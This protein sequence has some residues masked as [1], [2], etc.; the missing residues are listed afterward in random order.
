MGALVT[1]TFIDGTQATR[2]LIDS[3]LENY[4]AAGDTQIKYIDIVPDYVI[5]ILELSTG[6]DLKNTV[7][8][9]Q[10][11]ALLEEQGGYSDQEI[12]QLSNLYGSKTTVQQ[13]INTFVNM[14]PQTPPSSSITEYLTLKLLD[15]S[16]SGNTLIVKVQAQ[17]NTGLP[18]STNFI[19]CEIQ[20]ID[21]HTGKVTN[22]GYLDHNKTDLTPFTFQ[23]PTPSTSND[24]IVNI[25]M[26]DPQS[27]IALAAPLEGITVNKTTPSAISN[28][29]K[30]HLLRDALIGAALFVGVPA[31]VIGISK[32]SKKKKGSKK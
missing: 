18:D 28:E 19:R 13:W 17:A 22:A 31:A 27:D 29:I 2:F 9:W 1:L 25:F 32:L 11:K 23:E 16:F 4:I 21:R 20:V 30:N 15:T 14:T 26:I 7:L 10:V 8:T 5:N 3:A 6:A 12:I 24:L